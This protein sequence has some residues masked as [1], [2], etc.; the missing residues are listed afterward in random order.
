MAQNRVEIPGN[1][2]TVTAGMLVSALVL[3][4]T[5]P[6]TLLHQ[7]NPDDEGACGGESE[8]E[9]DQQEGE[10]VLAFSEHHIDPEH[11]NR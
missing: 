5:E 9:G 1:G 7:H 6:L 3:R 8:D 4:T 10:N 2:W 11:E